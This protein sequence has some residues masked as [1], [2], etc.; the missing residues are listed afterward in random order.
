M[1]NNFVTS[2]PLTSSTI[3]DYGEPNYSFAMK[4]NWEHLMELRPFSAPYSTKSLTLTLSV[5][6]GVI[7]Q[8]GPSQWVIGWVSM[9]SAQT[10]KKAH[11]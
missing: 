7:C 8:M 6:E 3:V 10:S 4:V 2:P 11:D 5:T 9:D 1:I